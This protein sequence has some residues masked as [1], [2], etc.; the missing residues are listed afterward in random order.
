L[1]V[2]EVFLLILA[3][4]IFDLAEDFAF[5]SQQFIL[6]TEDTREEQQFL[7][8]ILF[9]EQGLLVGALESGIIAD[10]V[11]E[12]QW[13]LQV[14]DVEEQILRDLVRKT[15]VG[16]ELVDDGATQG[17]EVLGLT[18]DVV[19]NRLHVSVDGIARGE[20]VQHPR[21]GQSFDENTHRVVRQAL[22]LQNLAD[23]A[24]FVQI[25]RFGDIRIRGFWVTRKMRSRSLVPARPRQWRE[26]EPQRVEKCCWK[27]NDLG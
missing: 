11:A 20:I 21:H 8:H 12:G 10:R 18:R 7:V 1:F 26:P 13:I 4:L 3:D 24:D 16:L 17:L 14:F 22:D 5:H 27:N 23:G 9:F 19:L 25:F 2:E 6:G 15:R